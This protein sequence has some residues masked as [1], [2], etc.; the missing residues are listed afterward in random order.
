MDPNLDVYIMAA[1][2]GCLGMLVGW[3]FANC[4]PL[5]G[6]T[7]TDGRLRRHLRGR[8]VRIDIAGTG[9]R[10]HR[11]EFTA[12]QHGLGTGSRPVRANSSS[13]STQCCAAFRERVRHF[14]HRA[15]NYRYL[16]A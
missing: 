10:K 11:R 13:G 1:G 15:G 6:G 9:A 3:V 7:P 14:L 4:V 16:W 2:A 8:V 12:F 5:D